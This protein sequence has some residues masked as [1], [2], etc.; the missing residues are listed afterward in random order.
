LSSSAQF[1]VQGRTRTWGD[2]LQYRLSLFERRLK[3]FDATTKLFGEITREARV[4]LGQLFTFLRETRECELLF[5]HEIKEYLDEVYKKGVDL[6]TRRPD[7]R[8]EDIEPETQL[9]IWFA[10]QFPVA[11][12]KFLKYLDFRE[13]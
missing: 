1:S 7:G 8:P 10:D 11:T 5:G 3:I 12:Q 6:H 9:L 13:P 4:D 2:R